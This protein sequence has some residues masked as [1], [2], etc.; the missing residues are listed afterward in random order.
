MVSDAFVDQNL[1]DSAA[2][3][4]NCSCFALCVKHARAESLIADFRQN[5]ILG[6]VGT[7]PHE[8]GVVGGFR[9]FPIWW[10]LPNMHLVCHTVYT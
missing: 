6:C 3:C 8:K 10:V 7:L 2:I 5:P 1:S 4:L 9:G